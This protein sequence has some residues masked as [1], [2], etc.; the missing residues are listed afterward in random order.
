[1]NTGTIHGELR[2]RNPVGRLTLGDLL[3]T[4][5]PEYAARCI[6]RKYGVRCRHGLL[7][8][9]MLGCGR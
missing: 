2:A 9:A 3:R 6:Q 5:G 7:V 4:K 8:A 1:M